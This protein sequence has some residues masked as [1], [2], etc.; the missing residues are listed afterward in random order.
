MARTDY[1]VSARS[2]LYR[3]ARGPRLRRERGETGG[4]LQRPVGEETGREVR[5][6]VRTLQDHPVVGLPDR[7]EPA[8]LDRGREGALPLRRGH[9]VVLTREDQGRYAGQPA[10]EVRA[11]PQRPVQRLGGV[12]G[13]GEGVQ[14]RAPHIASRQL[15]AVHLAFGVLAHQ[16]P[17]GQSGQPLQVTGLQPVDGAAPPLPLLVG[18]VGGHSA[19]HQPGDPAGMLL[20]AAEGDR[21]AVGEPEE[22]GPRYVQIVDDPG[23]GGVQDVVARTGWE[24]VRVAHAGQVGGHH[25][26]ERP[27]M[28]VHLR[29]AV[30]ALERAAEDDDRF[31]ARRGLSQDPVAVAQPVHRQGPDDLVGHGG[32]PASLVSGSGPGENECGVVS[33]ETERGLDGRVERAGPGLLAH[34]FDGDRGVRGVEVHGGRYEPVFQRQYGQ[35]GLDAAAWPPACVRSSPSSR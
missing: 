9:R 6:V 4:R 26:G 33:A 1:G 8:V 28:V 15:A 14:E 19:E 12:R 27:E 3:C 16:H 32:S 31:G 24:R 25:G 5:D 13:V 30:H 22:V 35:R 17:G 29:P 34:H 21:G 2:R 23:D 11:V 18:D 7:D 20:C 10:G